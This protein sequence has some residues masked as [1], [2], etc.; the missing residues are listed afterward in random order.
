MPAVPPAVTVPPDTL[1]IPELVVHAPPP[2]ALERTLVPPAHALNVPVIAD[3]R[4]LI[5]TVAVFV[6]AQ[7]YPG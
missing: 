6:F 3:G 4:G 7:L 2:V 5:V 1:A